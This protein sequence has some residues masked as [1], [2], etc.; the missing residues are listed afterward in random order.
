MPKTFE[1]HPAIGIA[2]VGNSAEFFIGPEPDGAPP[3]KYRDDIGKFKRQA[4]RFRVFEC[5]RDA[6]GKLVSASEIKLDR[7]Q[8]KWTVHLVNR[9]GAAPRFVG[10]GNRNNA[11]GDDAADA[12]LII[13]PGERSLTGPNQAAVLFDTGKFMNVVVPL[14]GIRTDDDGGLIVLGGFGASDSVPTQPDP[15][16]PL[17][18]F[19]D[20][21]FWHD[22][23]SDGPV[24][25][26]ITL[27]ANNQVVEAK[28]AWVIVAPPDFAPEVF[29]LIT[30]YDVAYQ[31]AVDRGFL[32]GPGLP[33]FMG[34]IHPILSRAVNYQWVNK[35]NR[36]GHSG[37]R[38]GNFEK[39]LA[40]LAD[41]ATSGPHARVI[42]NRLRNPN[43][44]PASPVPASAMPRLHDETN[45]E[46][47]LPL[48]R[49]QY[50]MLE[51]WAAGTYVNDL[52]HSL[53]AELIPDALD[54]V[55]LQACSGGAFFPGIEAGRIMKQADIYSEAFR[56]NA[57]VL[58]AGQITQGNALPWQADFSACAWEPQSF[59]G[60]WPAQRP[61]HVL[62]EASPTIPKD[63]ARG[64]GSDLDMV[65]HWHRLG[66]VVKR[67]NPTGEVFVETER[68]PTFLPR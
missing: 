57:N 67:T 46:Q 30:L 12:N 16:R 47:V 31:V 66:V 9:K 5:E 55:A 53:P 24:K 15:T 4:V 68:D 44:P 14:G 8:T 6:S 56:L 33:S 10:T 13:D 59:I 35:F 60:W 65:K 64:L 1:I 63:W 48:T 21:D 34:D 52:G 20:S 45:S 61:D 37:A 36:V 51:K 22:D 17:Q 42:L 40:V 7:A 58:K 62:R 39:D 18:G 28:A 49:T 19:A 54:R 23:T 50:A 27:T 2:R 29:N 11:A 43:L 26:T 41:P 3:A 32:T 25:A 38:P